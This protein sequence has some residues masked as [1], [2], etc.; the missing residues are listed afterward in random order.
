M[1]ESEKRDMQE[2]GITLGKQKIKEFVQ[3]LMKKW[4]E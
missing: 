1:N 3:Q 2:Y 4:E